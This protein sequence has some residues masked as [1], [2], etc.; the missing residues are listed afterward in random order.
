VTSGNVPSCM[1]F[2]ARRF[3]QS[4]A[5]TLS[6]ITSWDIST[7][8]NSE[9]R[10]PQHQSFM[11]EENRWYIKGC[12]IH[13]QHTNHPSLQQIFLRSFPALPIPSSHIPSRENKPS[14]KEPRRTTVPRY[15]AVA[16]G[17]AG[18]S[19]KQ[20]VECFPEDCGHPVFTPPD[21]SRNIGPRGPCFLLALYILLRLFA[22]TFCLCR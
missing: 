2:F 5:Q 15:T 1:S 14:S 22:A 20:G 3:T 17:S 19:I 18:V 6:S 12:S 4:T 9:S 10:Y 13:P 21:A 16:P 7:M 11:N 8:Y